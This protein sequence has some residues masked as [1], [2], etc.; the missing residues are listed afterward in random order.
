MLLNLSEKFSIL[1]GKFFSMRREVGPFLLVSTYVVCERL[2][3]MHYTFQLPEFLVQNSLSAPTQVFQE[4]WSG[5]PPLPENE[6][7]GRSW[8]FG[9]GL[10]WITTPLPWKMK[11]CAYLG[12]LN[13]RLVW[14]I[15]PPNENLDGAHMWRLISVSPVD[16]ISL[17]L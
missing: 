13:L 14:S 15:P 3:V 7:L 11:I 17:Y 1:D 6:T 9:F 16:T 8:H 2:S 12:T 5:V 10:V 4:C